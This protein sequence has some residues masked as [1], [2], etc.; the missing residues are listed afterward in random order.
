MLSYIVVVTYKVPLLR[1][2]DSSDIIV[3]RC[4]DEGRMEGALR[5]QLSA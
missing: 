2:T 4:P 3:A 5:M 1:G